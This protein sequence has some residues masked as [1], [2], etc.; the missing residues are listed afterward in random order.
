MRKLNVKLINNL[1]LEREWTLDDFAKELGVTRMYTWV[2][3]NKPKKPS[4]KTIIKLGRVFN[5]PPQD[6]LIEED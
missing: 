6:F 4:D 2:L 1:R 3:L 5:R